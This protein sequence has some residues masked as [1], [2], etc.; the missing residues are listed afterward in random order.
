[1]PARRRLPLWAAVIVAAVGGLTLDASFP[2]IGIWPLTFVA[3]ILGLVSLIGRRMGGAFLTGL[4][5]GLAF[6]LP[7]VSWSAHFLGDTTGA[8]VPWV[9]LSTFESL[10]T[11][12]LSIPIA[13]AYRWLPSTGS[14]TRALVAVL[15]AGLW[16]LREVLIGTVPYGGFAWG[17]LGM[18]MADAPIARSASW[19][20]VTGLS[21]CIVLISAFVIEI[22][23]P[24]TGSGTGK[25]RTAITPA[26]LLVALVLVPQFPTHVTGQTL[27]VGAVQGNGPAAYMDD[28][29]RY[30]VLDSQLEATE[31]LRGK[32]LDLIVWPEGGV[33]SDPLYNDTTAAVLDGVVEQYGAPLLMNAASAH[34]GDSTQDDAT[35][36]NTSMLWTGEGE[37]QLHSK[38]HPVPFGEYVP[39]RAIFEKLAPSLIGLIGREYTPGTEP[40]V[41]TLDDGT[42]IGLAICFDVIFDSLIR[43]GIHDGAEV[44]IFQTNNADFRGTDENLQQLSFARMR[45][46]ETGRMVVNLSTTGTSQ[47]IAADGTTVDALPIATAGAMLDDVELRTGTTAGVLLGPWI[48]GAILILSVLSL[49]AGGIRHRRRHTAS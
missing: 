32:D 33:D 4:V 19:I 14:G 35:I 8:W 44:L 40:P 41:V 46:I 6:Y 30:E 11:A 47:V 15:V 20:G 42:T 13:L 16:T 38:R 37:V 22:I 34:G 10:F 18:A 31:A 5:F 36:W 1:M 25:A 27:T 43:E 21:F 29:D 17:R 23:R 45:A 39:N 24:S 26:I 12:V 48:S 9:A 2:S 3:V 7:H 49:A 28:R